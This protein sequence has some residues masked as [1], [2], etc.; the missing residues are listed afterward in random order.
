MYVTGGMGDLDI[1]TGFLPGKEDPNAR[2][3]M[4]GNVIPD[5]GNVTANQ[6]YLDVEA[7]TS[8]KK[9]ADPSKRLAENVPGRFFVDADCIDCDMCRE[10]APKCFTRSAEELRSYVYRQP[11]SEEDIVYAKEAVLACPVA[12]I[13]DTGL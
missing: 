4:Q 10:V 12:A 5:V 11:V 1:R 6:R 8:Q 3:D 13:G 2:K 9:Q 7:G